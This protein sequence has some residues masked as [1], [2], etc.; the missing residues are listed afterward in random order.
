MAKRMNEDENRDM[1][2]QNFDSVTAFTK[3]ITEKIGELKLL[4]SSNRALS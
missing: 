3:F 1:K 4:D 2:A